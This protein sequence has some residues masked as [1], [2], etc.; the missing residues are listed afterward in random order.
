M[1]EGG[2][3]HVTP[4]EQ[5]EKKIFLVLQYFFDIF[6]SQLYIPK[7]VSS[8]FCCVVV[9]SDTQHDA[10]KAV[11][12]DTSKDLHIRRVQGSLSM[13]S[14]SEYLNPKMRCRYLRSKDMKDDEV[15][16]IRFCEQF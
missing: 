14:S 11:Q 15:S 9:A 12:E 13:Q 2:R 16:E 4:K 3:G 7:S 6:L 5:P 1:R 10:K 8:Y